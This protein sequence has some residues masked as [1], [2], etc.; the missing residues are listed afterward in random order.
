MKVFIEPTTDSRGIM[1]VRDALER[2]APGNFEIV[3]DIAQCDLA[4]LHVYGRHTTT[5]KTIERLKREGKAYAMIQYV[6][7]SSMKPDTKDWVEMW[8]GAKVVWSYYNLK[9]LCAEDNVFNS[10]NFYY[11]PLGVDAEV[12]KELTNYPRRKYIIAASSQHALSESA[13]ECV[14]AAKKVG[15]PM[16]F[17]GHD[18]RRGDDI[19]CRT[20]ITDQMLAGFYSQSTFVSGLRRTEGFELPVIEGLLCG[21]RPIVFDRPEMRHWFDKLAIHIPE[22]SREKV[23]DTLHGIFSMQ[24]IYPVT[25]SDEEKALVKERFNWQTIIEGFWSRVL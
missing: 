14:L 3:P 11:A 7:R 9:N 19:V 25:V 22:D 21:A 23:A 20:G 17:L 6:I 16:F 24:Q 15:K 2:Y 13:K 8:N 1:R 10:F 12:F 4:V 5:Q 18:L